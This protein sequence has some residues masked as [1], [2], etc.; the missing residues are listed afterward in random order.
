MSDPPERPTDLPTCTESQLAPGIDAVIA[1]TAALFTLVILSAA[2]SQDDGAD[3]TKLILASGATAAVFTGS[4]VVG[5]GRA[6]DCKQAIA[7]WKTRPVPKRREPV[8]FA[9][10]AEAVA[11]KD[12]AAAELTREAHAAA[13]EGKCA[14]TAANGPR[15]QYLDAEYYDKVFLVDDAIARCR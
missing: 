7:A 1:G 3:P 13:R 6:R 15:V 8:A 10:F 14:P 11:A 4:S 2:T 5:F 9:P 12:P